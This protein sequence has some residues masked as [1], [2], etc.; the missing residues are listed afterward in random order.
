MEVCLRL[1]AI[2]IRR[3]DTIR[4]DM[5]G[6]LLGQDRVRARKDGF[7]RTSDDCTTGGILTL[8]FMYS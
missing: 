3:Y 5:T 1:Y 4:Y 2:T 8:Q 6:E 7:S